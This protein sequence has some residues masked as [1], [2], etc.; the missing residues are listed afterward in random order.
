MFVAVRGSIRVI[1]ESTCQNL[2]DPLWTV[3]CLM[4]HVLRNFTSVA[5][6]VGPVALDEASCPT[7]AKTKASS[8][9]PSKP[10]KFDIRFYALVGWAS[11]Y[12]FSIW[13]NGTGSTVNQTPAKRFLKVFGEVWSSFNQF[14]QSCKS[15]LQNACPVPYDSASMLWILMVGLLFRSITGTSS[16]RRNEEAT[17][18]TVVYMDNYYTRHALARACSEFTDNA[19]KVTGTVKMNLVDKV[20]KLAVAQAVKDLEKKERGSWIL[21]RVYTGVIHPDNKLQKARE[22]KDS[23]SE[24]LP[25]ERI[26]FE[27]KDILE[28]VNE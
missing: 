16:S 26:G 7:K 2:D 9:L 3:R 22:K 14:T 13:D 8:Y 5:Y 19:V 28:V 27:E 20:N 11:V 4:S 6:V 1:S 24:S 18:R 15:R 25:R 17:A 12:T 23:Y 10:D 21:V